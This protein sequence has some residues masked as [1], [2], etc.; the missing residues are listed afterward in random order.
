MRNELV[1]YAHGLAEK[2]EIVALSQ[3]DLLDEEERAER[4]A[5]L[6]AELRPAG[7]G[8]VG[9]DGRGCR[10]SAARG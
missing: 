7:A 6:E 3:I 8:P 4:M 1:S 5:A 2:A 10:E 9:G